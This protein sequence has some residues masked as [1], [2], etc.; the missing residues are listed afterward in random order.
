MPVFAKIIAIVP[1]DRAWTFTESIG[2]RAVM[3]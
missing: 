1:D 2:E 3:R